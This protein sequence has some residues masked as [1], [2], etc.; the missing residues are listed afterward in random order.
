[1]SNSEQKG[2]QQIPIKGNDIEILKEHNPEVL[3]NFIKKI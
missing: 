1:M 3:Y 2:D